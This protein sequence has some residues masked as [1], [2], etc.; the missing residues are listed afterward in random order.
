[1]AS[2]TRAKVIQKGDTLPSATLKYAK[3]DQENP[4][5]CSAPQSLETT[6]FFKG[7]KAVLFAVPGAFTPTCSVNHLPGFVE[8]Y[9][10]LKEKGVDII[11]CIATNVMDA[12]GKNQAVEDKIL[13]LSDGNGE[14]CE[15]L[16]LIQDLT[17][18]SMGTHRAKRFALVVDDLKVEYV[19]VEA[20]PG[21]SVSGAESVL[22][23]L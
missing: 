5:A 16:G 20:G 18:A 21:V 3:Y 6:E 9:N 19:G 12:W 4:G 22:A 10:K 23:H 13:M 15:K 1:M 11:A 17:R 7:K 8:S 14:F 2:S